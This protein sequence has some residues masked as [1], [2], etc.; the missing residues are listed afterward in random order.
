M[1]LPIVTSVLLVDYVFGKAVTGT[2]LYELFGRWPFGVVTYVMVEVLHYLAL[3][4]GGRATAIMEKFSIHDPYGPLWGS[5]MVTLFFVAPVAL[6][7][8]VYSL[9]GPRHS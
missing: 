5:A 3:V 2:S 8:V 6:F 1:S 9:L 7:A 4:R